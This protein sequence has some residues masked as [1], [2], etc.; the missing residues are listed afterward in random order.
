MSVDKSWIHLR[1]RLSDEYWDGLCTFI[2]VG[3]NYAN[4][5]GGISCP[6][7]KCRN[8]EMFPPETVKAHIHRWG[9]DTSYT[10][11][12]HHDEVHA[13][14]VINEPV[15]EK[16]STTMTQQPMSVIDNKGDMHRRRD[17][18]VNPQ[19]EQIFHQMKG[20]RE[21]QIQTQSAID[22]WGDMHRSGAS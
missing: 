1:N 11:W 22:N 12:I 16:K 19:A 21:T 5:L 6:C 17:T 13:A 4:S 10:T 20:E 3:K 9:F 18:W 8:H 15:D 7:M 2:E 14:A